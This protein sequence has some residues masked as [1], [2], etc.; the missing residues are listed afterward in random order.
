M[1]KRKKK[2]KRA[3]ATTTTTNHQVYLWSHH[4]TPATQSPETRNAQCP[5]RTWC[6]WPDSL[7]QSDRVKVDLSALA[8][9][10]P[11]TPP[12]SYLGTWVLTWHTTRPVQAMDWDA[13]SAEDSSFPCSP[14]T[15][16]VRVRRMT[17]PSHASAFFGPPVN[18]F[19]QPACLGCC[20]PL[21]KKKHHGAEIH[22]PPLSWRTQCFELFTALGSAQLFFPRGRPDGLFCRDRDSLTA[23]C[24]KAK[25]SETQFGN[26]ISKFRNRISPWPLSPPTRGRCSGSTRRQ[27]RPRSGRP[28]RN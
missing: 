14:P 18:L 23:R 21:K 4:T 22:F 25:P 12:T 7:V 16:T 17:R 1:Q 15:P 19:T 20:S 24:V 6:P 3:F 26:R 5:C 9:S 2:Q 11:S 27:T 28:T 13:C 10:R 8:T